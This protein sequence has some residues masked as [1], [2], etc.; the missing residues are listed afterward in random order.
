MKTKTI[1]LSVLCLLILSI[2]LSSYITKATLTNSRT[3]EYAIV[4]V[5]ER[6]KTKFIRVTIG[7]NPTTESEWKNE[8]TNKRD[9]YTP[10]IAV[11]NE[12]NEQGFE[13]LNS[14]VAYQ[15]IGGGEYLNYGEP[16]HTFIMVK[17]IK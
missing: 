14:S 17:K 6:G 11:L 2:I 9:D 13:L 3:E 8:K 1:I 7:I 16:R 12:L 15:T 4:D 5:V 10:V